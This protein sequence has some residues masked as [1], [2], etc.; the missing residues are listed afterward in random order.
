MAKRTIK[1]AVVGAAGRMGQRIIDLIAQ[2]EGIELRGAVERPSHPLLGKEIEAYTGIDKFP[3]KL[4]DDLKKVLPEIDVVIDFSEAKSTLLNVEAINIEKKAVVIG[5]T[6]FSPPEVEELKRKLKGIPCVFSPNMSIGVNLMFKVVG[7]IAQI[8]KDEFE[9][10]I[11]EAHHRMKKD[12]PSGTAIH[13]AKIIAEALNR[14]LS[15]VGIY[16]RKGVIGERKTQEI[17]IHAVR[18]GDIVGE[19]TVLFA[20][21][22]ERIEV[23]H[24]AH[25][26]DTFARG[27]VKA[28]LWIVDQPPGIYGMEDVLG[29]RD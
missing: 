14:D 27:A 5:T 6:G 18:A 29:L 8:L 4:T 13:L 23:T 12:A 20:G 26:R 19:H 11:I 17:G 7:Y 21:F 22:G 9:V 24:R 28:A 10:E 25:S 2:T 15:Q 16:G 1:A 3:V